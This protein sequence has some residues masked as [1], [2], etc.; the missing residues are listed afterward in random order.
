MK[1]TCRAAGISRAWLDDGHGSQHS[2]RPR[3][4]DDSW[5]GSRMQFH[6][7]IQGPEELKQVRRPNSG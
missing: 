7:R 3:L 1:R 2:L 4:K 6:H 5:D